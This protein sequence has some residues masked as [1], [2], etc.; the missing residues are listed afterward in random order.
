[1]LAAAQLDATVWDRAEQSAQVG[2]WAWEVDG[3]ELVWSAN[4]YR[5]MGWPPG[6][7]TPTLR[8]L[9]ERIHPGDVGHVQRALEATRAGDRHREQKYRIVRP[10]GRIRHLLSAPAGERL[11][12]ENGAGQRLVLGLVRDVTEQRGAERAVELYAA[13]SRALAEWG[14]FRTGA[15]RLRGGMAAA[16]EVPAAGL[17]LPDGEVLAPR[18]LWSAERLQRSAFE[19]ELGG[20]EISRGHGLAGNA[21][22][23]G[24]PLAVPL[25]GDAPA[26]AEPADPAPDGLVPVLA[27]PAPDGGEVLA[28]I[29]FFASS[30]IDG[31]ERLMSAFAALGAQ[32]GSF[33]ARRPGLQ[34]WSL[35][36]RETE[37]LKLAAQGLPGSQIASALSLSSATVKTHLANTYAK[38][39]VSSRVAAVAHALREG[40]IE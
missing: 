39:G 40:L 34:R 37:V 15:E 21:W 10:D 29:V 27:L 16:L 26:P 1:M 30:P 25:R 13:V 24:G 33:L 11:A 32:L 5:L 3:D 38:I 6:A 19:R 36:P 31:G 35:T 28:V 14:S 23:Q 18:V 4:L 17:W 20:L 9:F 22:E 2:S 8:H 7:F 12:A